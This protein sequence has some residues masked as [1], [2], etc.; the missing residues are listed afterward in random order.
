VFG[1]TIKRVREDLVVRN[2]K[3]IFYYLMESIEGSVRE[4]GG[5]KLFHGQNYSSDVASQR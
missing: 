2:Q 4:G 3:G 1:H 5:P